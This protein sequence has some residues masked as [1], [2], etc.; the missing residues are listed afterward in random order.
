M[1]IQETEYMAKMPALG[2]GV[3]GQATQA[4]SNGTGV[5][6]FSILN[7]NG[8]Y[9]QN[10][11]TGEGVYGFANAGGDGVYGASTTG[12]LA[13]GVWGTNS[14]AAN[15]TGVVGGGNNQSS[16]VLASGTGGAFTGKDIGVFGKVGADS[17]LAATQKAGGYFYSNIN[18]Y[19]YVGAVTN[20][21]VIR[22]IEGLGTVNT[23]VKDVNNNKVVL[24]APEAPEDLFQDYGKGQ[25]VNGK[26]HITLDPNFS[27]NIVVN[28]QHDLRVFV[29]LE[30]DCNGV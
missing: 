15:G 12:P 20:A 4:G 21:N 7:G 18:A 13:F 25:L 5:G 30:G 11:G 24:C 28:Q 26:A 17:T 9:G 2:M 10:T 3:R 22:K 19:V 27:K 29:Q 14:S 6:G 1:L 23:V 16:F 8:V